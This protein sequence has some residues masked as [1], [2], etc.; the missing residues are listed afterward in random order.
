MPAPCLLLV[1]DTAL[2]CMSL[3]ALSV[4]R[5]LESAV[6]MSYEDGFDVAGRL[7]DPA[8]SASR[9]VVWTCCIG[10]AWCVHRCVPLRAARWRCPAPPHGASPWSPARNATPASRPPSLKASGELQEKVP[11]VYTHMRTTIFGESRRAQASGVSLGLC[12]GASPRMRKCVHTKP[13]HI[14]LHSDIVR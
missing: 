6:V 3:T 9:P 7:A 12:G 4:R 11:R 2:L 13:S 8:L 1:A 10:G 5:L 14:H